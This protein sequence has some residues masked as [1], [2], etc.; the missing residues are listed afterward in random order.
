MKRED[1]IAPENYNIIMEMERHA[2]TSPDR[3][4]LIWK[5][6]AGHTKEITYAELIKNTNKI[7]NAFLES[8][9]KK[10]D[11]ILVIIPRIIEAYEVYLAALK[12]GI[13]IRVQKC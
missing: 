4:A 12:T 7:G 5:D 1:L 11:K 10:G 13:V 3:M 2:T 9:L 8:G 6:E